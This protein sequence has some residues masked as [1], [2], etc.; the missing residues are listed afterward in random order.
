MLYIIISEKNCFLLSGVSYGRPQKVIASKIL[1]EEEKFSMS[2]KLYDCTEKS[3]EKQEQAF[4]IYH[5]RW[6]VM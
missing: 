4:V 5:G 1:K 3:S 6:K 2:K